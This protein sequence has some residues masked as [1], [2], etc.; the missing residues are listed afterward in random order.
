MSNYR[1][2][3]AYFQEKATHRM[4]GPNLDPA[5]FCVYHGKVLELGMGGQKV[6]WK[7]EADKQKPREAA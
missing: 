3:L 7:C 4:G 6:C 1:D 5:R 2:A